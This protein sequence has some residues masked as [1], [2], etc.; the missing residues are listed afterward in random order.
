[1]PARRAAA[2]PGGAARPQ[3]AL[4]LTRPPLDPYTTIAVMRNTGENEIKVSYASTNLAL[5]DIVSGLESYELVEIKRIAPFGDKTLVEAVGLQSGRMVKRPLAAEEFAVLVK[6]RGQHYVC[7][8]DTRLFLLGAEAER[9]RIAYQFD[10]LFAVNSSIVDPLP[11]QVEAVYRYL[12]PLPR[13]RFLLADD[14][15]AGKTIMTGLLIKELLFRGVLQKVL[16]ITPGGL[17]KQWKEEEVQEKFG[18]YPRLVNRASFDSDPGQFSRY[19]VGIF[20]TSIDFLAR[21]EGCLKA[22][23]ATHW[24][25]VVVDEAHKL[26]AYEHGT[27]LEESERYKAVKALARKTDHL[28]FLTG[29]LHRGIKDTFRRLLLLLDEDLLQDDTPACRVDGWRRGQC[30]EGRPQ[31]RNLRGGWPQVWS[32]G[33]ERPRATSG[34]WAGFETS[35]YRRAPSVGPFLEAGDEHG[36]GR[37]FRPT[38]PGSGPAVLEVGKGAFRCSTPRPKSPETGQPLAERAPGTSCGWRAYG[39]QGRSAE[40]VRR[41]GVTP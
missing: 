14:T 21:N 12:L 32:R 40:H 6:V 27:K 28:L 24:D 18:L 15:G 36:L 8:G 37:E 3:S 26:S 16:I 11:H 23:S 19:E 33:F 22:A 25:L 2:L 7:D 10:P 29:T 35:A 1:L 20:T 34:A 4:R 39:V 9:I 13:I 41:G 31:P 5:G 17:T 30:N 38:E